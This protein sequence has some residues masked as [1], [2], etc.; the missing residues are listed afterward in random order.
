MLVKT[1]GGT[2]PRYEYRKVKVSGLE[3]LGAICVLGVVWE[4]AWFVIS[5][6]KHF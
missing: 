2:Y 1:K 3:V 4:I 6:V 5:I